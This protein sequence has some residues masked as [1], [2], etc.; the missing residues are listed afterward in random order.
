MT[1]ARDCSEQSY[2]DGLHRSW[3]TAGDC[4]SAAD[5]DRIAADSGACWDDRRSACAAD[6]VVD[7]DSL[8][9][10]RWDSARADDSRQHSTSAAEIAG[11]AADDRDARSAQT[12][13]RRT[14]Q[15]LAL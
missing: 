12:R 4:R 7:S 15:N 1:E 2:P 11:A 8:A 14:V 5:C 9:G 13:L 3:R 6:F 10:S